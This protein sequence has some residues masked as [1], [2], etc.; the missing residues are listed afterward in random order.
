MATVSGLAVAGGLLL[1][2]LVLLV[3]G[4]LQWRQGKPGV[5]IALTIIG[6][7]WGLLVIGGAGFAVY[8][9]SHYQANNAPVNFNA[10]TYKGPLGT[11]TTLPACTCSLTMRPAKGKPLQ[12]FNTTTGSLR[13]PA[14]T[15]EVQ[16]WTCSSLPPKTGSASWVLSTYAPRSARSFVVTANTTTPLPVGPP[17]TARITPGTVRAGK[18]SL[19]LALTDAAGNDYTLRSYGKGAANP[20]FEALDSTGKVV[21]SGKFEYG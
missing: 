13:I 12:S 16:S 7:L 17:L 19:N 5:G 18:A 3:L 1:G 11:V 6:G 8:Q 14:G 10:A 21:W 9:F 2:W 15:Y 20:G 4:V